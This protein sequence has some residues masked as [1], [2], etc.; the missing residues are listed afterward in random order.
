MPSIPSPERLVRT[1]VDQA[2]AGV[3][4]AREQ[5]EA[6]TALPAALM[7]LTRAVGS[8]DVTIRDAQATVARLQRVGERLEAILDEVEQ[9]VKDLAPGLRRV[10]EVLDD[11]AVS[12]LPDTV[13]RVREDLLPLVASLRGGADVLDRFAGARSLLGG[14]RRLP[15]DPPDTPPVI[16]GDAPTGPDRTPDT[17]P[18]VEAQAPAGPG[19]SPDTPPVTEGQAP[20]GPGRSPDTPP[21][22]EG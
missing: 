17:P 12:D 13:R 6:I 20:A 22:T 5:A 11:P 19:R 18:V 7:S 2:G 10:G 3:R 1:V 14:F 21:V 9:P 4:L 15:T 16:D 8:L